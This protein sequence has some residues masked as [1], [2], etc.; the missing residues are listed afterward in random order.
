MSLAYNREFVSL[1]GFLFGFDG[2]LSM[3]FY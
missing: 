1:S 3:F 2:F